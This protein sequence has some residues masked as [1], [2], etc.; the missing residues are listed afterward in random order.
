MKKSIF[1]LPLVAMG[2][3]SCQNYFDEH[4]L[5]NANPKVEDIRTDMA[6]TFSDDDYASVSKNADNIAK[7]YALCTPEDSSAY[8]N[9]LAIGKNKCFTE[10][11]SA[12]MYAAPILQTLF[13]YIDNGSFCNVTYRL[14]EGKS[15]RVNKFSEGSKYDFVLADYE[16]IWNGHG[17][18]YLTPSSEPLVAD[19]LLKKFPTAQEGKILLISYTYSDDEPASILPFLSYE[20]TV[21]EILE[22]KETTEHQFT[23]T[24]GFFK[25]TVAKNTGQ[26]YLKDANGV[27]SILV[28][29]MKHEDGSKVWESEGLAYGDEITIKAFYSEESGTPQLTKAIFISKNNAP[30]PARKVVAAQRF[31]T[32]TVIYQLSAGAWAIYADDQLAAAKA[33]PQDVYTALGSAT[34][35][36]PATT[37]GTWLRQ[38]YPYAAA[39]QVYLVAYNSA[40]GVAADEWTYDGTDFVL[41]TGYVD[42]TMSFEVKNNLWIPNISTYLKQAFVGE[43]LGK[44]TIQHVSL[45]GLSYIWRYQAA[46]GAT[47]SAYVSSVNH[48]VEDWFISPTI[49]LKKSV[50]PQISFMQAVRYGNTTDN[51]TWLNVMVTNNFTGDVTTTEWKKLNFPE[52]MPDGSNWTFL[53]TGFCDLSEFNGQAIVIAFRYKTDFEGIEVPSAPTWEIQHLLV[54]EPEEKTGDTVE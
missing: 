13:P 52:A 53:T 50:H 35:S 22:A 8:T 48:R 28:Y 25:P 7:A 24:I 46:Y 47:A 40:S 44:F 17:A 19:Y 4:Y 15:K 10:D 5:D 32:K 29:S 1:L 12:D 42:E 21:H 51:P 27:D 39:D 49:R 26:F 2:L 34:I 23:G 33:L 45:D 37:I 54:A 31:V 38:T 11:A 14:H 43:G 36:N 30:A 20:C 9:L 3:A 6:Y 18:N 16:A 41:T